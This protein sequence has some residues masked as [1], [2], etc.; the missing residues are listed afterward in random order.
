MSSTDHDAAHYVYIRRM[1]EELSVRNA[2]E[3]Q[4]REKA[5]D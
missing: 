5:L 3:L 4:K 2:V 1:N